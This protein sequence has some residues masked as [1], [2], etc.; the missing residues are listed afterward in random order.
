MKMSEFAFRY[1]AEQAGIRVSGCPRNNFEITV[2]MPKSSNLYVR[3]FAGELI[4]KGIAGD[5][6]VELHAGH[7]TMEVGK[8]GRLCPRRCL[9]THRR[10]PGLGL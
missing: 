9:S 10:Y 8:P 6:D 7:L 4:V 1:P 5:K 3:M 2:E